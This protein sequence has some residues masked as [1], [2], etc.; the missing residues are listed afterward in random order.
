[1]FDELLVP[2]Q[3]IGASFEFL[4]YVQCRQRLEEKRVRVDAKYHQMTY[5]ERFLVAKNS[6]H[7]EDEWCSTD[8]VATS[9]EGKKR[10]DLRISLILLTGIERQLRPKKEIVFDCKDI[11]VT[12]FWQETKDEIEHGL[13]IEID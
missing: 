5:Q 12:F 6:K 9:A 10:S 4:P 7:E 2:E 1:M 13:R 11:R 8:D 3:S